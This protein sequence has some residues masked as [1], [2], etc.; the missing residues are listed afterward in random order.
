MAAAKDDEKLDSARMFAEGL[1]SLSEG[2]GITTVT[3]IR[4]ITTVTLIRD[5][6]CNPDQGL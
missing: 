5:Y 3:L 4:E 1:S 6:D 2:F